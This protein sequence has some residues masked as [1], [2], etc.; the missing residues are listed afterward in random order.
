MALLIRPAA[1]LLSKKLGESLGYDFVFRVNEAEHELE[2]TMLA[3]FPTLY[4]VNE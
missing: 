1:Q 4:Q 3:Y 2:N